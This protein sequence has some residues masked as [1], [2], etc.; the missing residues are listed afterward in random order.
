MTYVNANINFGTGYK[1]RT[2]DQ[3]LIKTLHYHCANPVNTCMSKPNPGFEELQKLGYG[4]Y[5]NSVSYSCI[6]EFTLSFPKKTAAEFI[7]DT[8]PK[9]IGRPTK[10][11][12]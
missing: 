11:R 9:Q 12:T 6:K 5:R 1:I 8:L 2:C 4:T 10:N 7:P 3:R